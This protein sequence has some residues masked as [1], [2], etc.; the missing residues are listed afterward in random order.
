[1][2]PLKLFM[3]PNREQKRT[4]VLSHKLFCTQDKNLF[5]PCLVEQKYYDE[6]AVELELF[7][8]KMNKMSIIGS[9][10]GIRCLFDPWIQDP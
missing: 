10:A 3:D 7:K 2:G 5:Y 6:A 9:G 8:K 4:F 1:M